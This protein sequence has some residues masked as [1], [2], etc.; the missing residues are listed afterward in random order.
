MESKRLQVKN[1]LKTIAVT[2]EADGGLNQLCG[3]S[4]KEDWK[5][6]RVTYK[7]NQQDPVTDQT[8]EKIDG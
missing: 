8:G 1:L 4:R 6:L 5:D 7:E 3:N 2:E